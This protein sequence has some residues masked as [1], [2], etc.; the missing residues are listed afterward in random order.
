[1]RDPSSPSSILV[2]DDEPSVLLALRVALEARGYDVR[3]APDGAL[4]LQAA[5]A[6]RP[7]V[8]VLDLAMPGMD[9][10]EVCRRLRD[11]TRV[12]I[13]VLSAR[14]DEADKVRALDAGAD[15]YLTK[16]FGN[17]ELLARVRAALRREEALREEA[18][19]LRF[20]DL[21][22]DFADHRV[23]MHGE[24]VHLTPTELTLLRVLAVNA[25]RVLTHRYLLRAVFG[26]G[27][28]DATANL[29]VFVGQLRRKIERDPSRPRYIVSEPGV[30]YRFRAN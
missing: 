30:G 11:W 21:V 25:D 24:H 27:Y 12:P 20:G 28:E 19:V 9:G 23:S 18:P 26:P 17:E 8:I 29:R 22:I 4:A 3:T 2:I 16:P 14:A 6:R 1:M 10:F 15:D 5:A 13:I 7:D